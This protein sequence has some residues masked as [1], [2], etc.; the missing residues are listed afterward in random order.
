M[1]SV[2]V[3]TQELHRVDGVDKEITVEIEQE[4]WGKKREMKETELSAF[5]LR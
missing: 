2:W 1:Y 4:V 5:K 3:N